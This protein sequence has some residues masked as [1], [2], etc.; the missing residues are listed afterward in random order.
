MRKSTSNHSK[1]GS[2]TVEASLVLPI[3]IF[4]MISIISLSVLLMFQLRLKVVMHEVCKEVVERELKGDNFGEDEIEAEILAMLGSKV[5]KLAPIEDDLE[6]FTDV[7]ND[8][9]V[10]ICAQYNTKLYYDMF[11]LFKHEFVQRSLLHDFKGYE[12]G[13]YG[14]EYETDEITYVYITE[15]SEVYH[16]NRECTHIRLKISPIANEALIGARNNDGKKYKS[17]EHCHSKT[18][19]KNLYI[20]PE[21][22]KYHNSLTCSGLKRVVKTVP[23]SEVSGKRCCTRCGG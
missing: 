9:I 23:L 18:G 16:T 14:L 6:F 8:E 10:C 1:E 3:F 17:C 21:G 19:D 11:G 13:L 5:L 2:L 4:A 7:R 15:D 22:D 20:T 12:K